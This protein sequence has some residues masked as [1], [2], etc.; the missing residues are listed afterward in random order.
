M[1]IIEIICYVNVP[2]PL[3][4]MLKNFYLLGLPQAISSVIFGLL[5]TQESE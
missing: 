3:T 4:F 5:K 1:G 2:V